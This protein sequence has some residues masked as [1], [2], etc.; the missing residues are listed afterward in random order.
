MWGERVKIIQFITRM[1]VLGGAQMHVCELS[2]ALVK[3]GHEVVVLGA[4][5][6]E[7]SEELKEYRITYKP[8]KYVV[9]PI[10]PYFDV[11]AF[12]EVREIMKEI[13]P[14]IVALHSSKAGMIGRL[15]GKSLNIPTVFTAHSWS[16]AGEPSRKKKKL[17][18]LMEKW[19]GKF[20]NGVITVSDFDYKQAIEKQI[21]PM[22]KI[23]RIH[24]GIYDIALDKV[25]NDVPTSIV[26]LL[27]VA[28]FAE[29]KDHCLLLKALQR[30]KTKGWHLTLVGDGPLFESVNHFAKAIGLAD[31]ITFAGENRDVTAKLR[32]TDIFMLISKSEGLPLSIIEA[33]R[34]GLP[35]IAS[36]VGGTCE[37]IDHRRNGLLV[38]KGDEDGLI[39]ALNEMMASDVLR[40]QLGKASRQKFMSQFIFSDMYHQTESFYSDIARA[41]KGGS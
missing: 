8:L 36:D 3:D 19:V 17:F 1:D 11:L 7:L 14:D 16:F 41:A 18:I 4:G 21:V 22:D 27:M 24:N 12:F 26:R 9:V 39:E 32:E 40:K 20:T 30:V 28:R 38:P 33:M 29:P 15:A 6:G 35:I 23:Q 31:Q 34:E 5:T 13:D 10:K 37:L 2:K 25:T